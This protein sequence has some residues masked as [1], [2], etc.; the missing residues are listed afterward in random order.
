MIFG[1]KTTAFSALLFIFCLYDSSFS[2][3]LTSSF[4]AQTNFFNGTVNYELGLK[5]AGVHIGYGIMFPT[6]QILPFEASCFLGRGRNKLELGIGGICF[7]GPE[8]KNENQGILEELIN[9]VIAFEGVGPSVLPTFS[10][11]YRYR[12][13]QKK[14]PYFKAGVSSVFSEYGI[15]P[16]LSLALGFSINHG[17][18][19]Y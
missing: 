1:K 13:P 11:S 19:S 8:K 2:Q 3:K 7:W 16:S 10:L 9:K 15:F 6:L 18:D 12:S 14:A 17:K 5:N 4:F